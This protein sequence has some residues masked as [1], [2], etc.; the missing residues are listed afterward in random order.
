MIWVLRTVKI[1]SLI[2]SRV[3]RYGAKTGEKFILCVCVCVCVRV[4]GFTA[5][6]TTRSCRAGQLIVALYLGRLRPSKR[7]TSTNR[8]RPRQ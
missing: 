4:G 6:S 5:E 2:L 8:G 7:L 3:N 1:I